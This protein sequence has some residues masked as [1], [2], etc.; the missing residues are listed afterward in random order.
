[1]Q[2]EC[3]MHIFMNGR[4]YGEAVRAMEEN[5]IEETVRRHLEIYRSC[6]IKFLRD[7]GDHYGASA[8]AKKLAPDY[9]IDYRTPVFAIHKK[10]HYGGIV[11]KGFDTKEAYQGL[12][13]EAADKG[14][15]FIK[16]M[17]SGLVDF[18]RAAL[19]EESL[20]SGEIET[21]I[22]MAHEEGFSVMA[23]VNGDEAAKAAAKAGAESIEHGY[24]IK[25]GAIRAMAAHGT[26]YVPTL[27][28]TAN[29]M[30]KGRF[31]E[32][33]LK[34]IF[35]RQSQAIEKCCQSGVQLAC[36][37][38]AG[39]YCVEHGRGLSDEERRLV[40]I[41]TKKCPADGESL[42]ESRVQEYLQRGEKLIREKFKPRF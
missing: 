32:A 37:S 22:G 23:H 28:T 7:G 39:A 21:M 38:D 29:L 6:G 20:S 41:L 36:G 3:H 34:E 31:P 17:L 1:M 12:L 2:G 19:T 11:G 9:G 42:P 25:D 16:L 14:A 27:V 26:V 35:K 10:G 30:G 13:H 33:M 24:F 8:L 18:S 5:R 4:S 40:G 15:D